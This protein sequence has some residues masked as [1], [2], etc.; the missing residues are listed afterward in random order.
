MDPVRCGD[1]A[2]SSPG[3]RRETSTGAQ[4]TPNRPYRN[5]DMYIQF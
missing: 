2:K 4:I 3:D 1:D 5:S